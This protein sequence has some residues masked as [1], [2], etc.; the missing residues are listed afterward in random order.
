MMR[1]HYAKWGINDKNRRPQVVAIRSRQNGS[2]MGVAIAHR[3]PV[4][5]TVMLSTQCP[6][7]SYVETEEFVQSTTP[8]EQ[9]RSAIYQRFWEILPGVALETLDCYYHEIC[10]E[11]LRWQALAVEY[12][13]SPQPMCAE[14]RPVS[15]LGE[16]MRD[17]YRTASRI[18]ATESADMPRWRL[19]HLLCDEAHLEMARQNPQVCPESLDFFQIYTFA[20]LLSSVEPQYNG[21]GSLWSHLQNF[22]LTC[23]TRTFGPSHPLALVLRAAMIDTNCH[24]SFAR[25]GSLQFLLA[26]IKAVDVCDVT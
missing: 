8:S 13:S 15:A 4:Q 16:I 2:F 10:T 9:A 6:R 20:S 26:H 24:L 25:S 21:Q 3:R 23:A 19:L 7:D 11:V 5:D 18:K 1:D 14:R 12:N 22:L 17:L